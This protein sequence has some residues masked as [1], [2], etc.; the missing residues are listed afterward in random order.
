MARKQ[1]TSIETS[2]TTKNIAFVDKMDVSKLPDLPK[3]EPTLYKKD[4]YF[5][6]AATSAPIVS[7]I[8]LLLA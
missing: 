4:E 2:K 1:A 7:Q 8:G 5:T 6:P 3:T